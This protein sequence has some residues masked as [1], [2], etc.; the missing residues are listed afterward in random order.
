MFENSA[1]DLLCC[2]LPSA[3]LWSE[4]D[5]SLNLFELAYL[6]NLVSVIYATILT[7]TVF[8]FCGGG[9]GGGGGGG[10]LGPIQSVTYR[11]I[12][13]KRKIPDIVASRFS[14]VYGQVPES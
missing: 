12:K 13:R 4:S 6:S 14:F 9:G 2:S 8:T 11:M 7:H 10:F 1:S 3:E 5:W